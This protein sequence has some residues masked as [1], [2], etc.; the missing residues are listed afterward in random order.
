MNKKLFVFVQ[1]CNNDQVTIHEFPKDFDG[2][3]GNFLVGLANEH[4]YGSDCKF[5]I[6]SLA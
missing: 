3:V 5:F 6:G 2:S 1:N 4:N